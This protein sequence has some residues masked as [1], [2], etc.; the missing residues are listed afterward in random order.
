[1]AETVL[2]GAIEFLQGFGFFD[3]ILPFILI[4]T[5]VFGILE[6]T[7]IFGTEKIKD[8]EYPKKNL[9]AMV[10]FVIAFFVVAAKEVVASLKASLP[11]VALILVAAISF[12]M[13]FGAM[14]S[15]EKIFQMWDANKPL[16]YTLA[17]IFFISVILIFFYAVGWLNAIIA[18]FALRP[19]YD[20]LIYIIFGL[21]TL[22]LI[23]Y[24]TSSG[25]RG[26]KAE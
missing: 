15:G 11:L 23:L 12:F 14:F 4:F 5:V 10:A 16:A 22:G 9:N 3:I 26:G 17:I 18:W 2:G 6:K 19:D 24:I 25:G 13:L 7:K 8:K 21:I 1:M 20:I